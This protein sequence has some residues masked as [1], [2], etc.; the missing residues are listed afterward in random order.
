MAE[1]GTGVIVAAGAVHISQLFIDIAL[2]MIVARLMGALFKRIRQPAV[3]GEIIAGI[4]LGPTLL[5]AFPGD[6]TEK[7]FPTDIRPSLTVVAQLGLIIFMFI[8]GLELDMNLI[9]GKERI[10]AVISVCS[11]IAPFAFGIGLAYALY[12]SHDTVDGQKVPQLAFALFIGA[13][14][15]VTAFP[16]LAR[17]LTERGMYRTEIGALTLACAAVDDILA[18]SLLALVLAV[19]KTGSIADPGLLKILGYSIVFI[20]FMFG[21]VKP[22]LAKIVPRFKAAGRLTPNV[23]SIVLIGILVSSFITDKIGI[24]SIFGAFTFGAIMPRDDTHD[25][26]HEI[27]EKLE[28]VSVLLL[29]PVFFIATGLNVNVRG[30]GLDGLGQLAL[31]LLAACAGKFIGATFGAKIQGLSNRKAMAIGTLMNTRGLTEL[32]ILNVGREFGVLDPQLFTMLVLMAIFTTVITEPVLRA[33]YPDRLLR[34]DIAEAERAALGLEDAYRVLVAVEDPDTVQPL[35]DLA[36]DLVGDEKPSEIVLVRSLVRGEANELGGGVLEELGAMTSTMDRM[37]ALK[38]IVEARGVRCV[39]L[40]KFTTD[41]T[42]DLLATA[43][44]TEA[45]VVLVGPEGDADRLRAEV[46]R[47]FA[48]WRPGISI[49]GGPVVMIPGEN[50]DLDTALET[51]ARIA[52]SQRAP[53]V[54]ADSGGRGGRKLA[55]AAEQ[56]ARIGMDVRVQDADPATMASAALVVTGAGTAIDPTAPIIVVRADAG[57]SQV[58]VGRLVERATSNPGIGVSAS[59]E[60]RTDGGASVT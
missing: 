26:F 42:S 15:S 43:E 27:L 24:H 60:P 59:E 49:P 2:I 51:A 31:I 6:L 23:L 4:L 7:V 56:L 13:S 29:L 34:R 48:T 40:S 9:R 28:Q 18:W 57:D 41:V 30:L 8:V 58:G 46:E 5:G 37:N 44:A 47:V 50:R 32:V 19:V 14:M 39:V 3:V 21:V 36:V 12:A 17:I 20:V 10:A 11:I 1:G 33:V 53:L 45:D 55:Q 25:L 35:L 22:Q 16:V 52:R 38:A 54:L